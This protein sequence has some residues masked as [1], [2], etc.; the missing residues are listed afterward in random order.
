MY[1]VRTLLVLVSV[2]LSTALG[3]VRAS[4]QNA[5]S[6]S[7]AEREARSEF[8]AG[9]QAY[10]HGSFDEALTHFERAHALSPRP[11]LLYNIGRAADSEGKLE[12]AI[13]AYSGYLEALP[14][15]GNRDFVRG[16][17]NKLR[18]ASDAQASAAVALPPPAPPAEGPAAAASA[19]SAPTSEAEPAPKKRSKGKGPIGD[20][21]IGVQL[22][23]AL[24]GTGDVK[25]P[26]YI[27]NAST[28][29][30][31]TLQAAGVIGSNGCDVTERYCYTPSR[32]GLHLSI[33]IQ[34][35]GTIVGYRFEPYFTFAENANAYGMYT[36]PTFDFRIKELPLYLGFGFGL[37]AAW[38]KADGWKYAADLYGRIPVHAI[39][40]M[41]DDLAL[42]LELGFGG[43]ASVYVSER[44]NVLN[45]ANGRIIAQKTDVTA[46]FGRTWDV[47]LGLRFP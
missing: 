8:E 35:G 22:G 40:Y 41:I 12:R 43:G 7:S 5:A 32:S 37:K 44:K 10:E 28:L 15:A 16:R 39:W 9:R 14:E 33:P 19:P 47:S 24:V 36:G 4:A 11:E 26:T 27:R 21:G 38:V 1:S 46:G 13:E 34:I 2:V 42:V 30:Q 3:S 17:L 18:A 6:T 20:W 31:S 29:P 45:P 25:N 23:Y